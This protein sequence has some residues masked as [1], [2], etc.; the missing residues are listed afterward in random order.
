MRR[1][2]GRVSQSVISFLT[3]TSTNV[4]IRPRFSGDF[5]TIFVV[6]LL[7]VVFVWYVDSV[8]GLYGKAVLT[9]LC[10]T[11]PLLALFFEPSQCASQRHWASWMWR[12]G[13]AVVLFAVLVGI[14]DKWNL[15]TL[16]MAI[17]MIGLSSSLFAVCLFLS[18][19]K[20]LLGVAWAP[21]IIIAMLYAVALPPGERLFS[22]LFL[23]F[24]VFAFS[25]PFVTAGYVLLHFTAKWRRH[26]V[27]GPGVE[28]L[29]MI[30]LFT[31]MIWLVISDTKA[32]TSDDIWLALSLTIVGVLISSIV[33]TPF[34]KF[35]LALGNL[36]PHCSREHDADG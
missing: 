22:M 26:P 3:S 29:M 18:W 10:S 24:M 35:L 1:L 17:T 4:R 13:T 25:I 15:D 32:I 27:R 30:V 5:W 11:L 21:S 6:W 31:P 36:P 7:L 9:L 28:C 19:K 33:S 14:T 23:L 12:V 20:P 16:G 8:D 34:R 2:Y